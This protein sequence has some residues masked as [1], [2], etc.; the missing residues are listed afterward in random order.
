VAR[1]TAPFDLSIHIPGMRDSQWKKR[2]R[3][4]MRH[5]LGVVSS[6]QALDLGMSTSA[7]SRMV[8]SGAWIRVLPRVYRDACAPITF[9]Q[10]LMA[11]L[12]WAGEGSFVSHRAAAALWGL[13]AFDG[14]IVEISCPRYL[15]CP[16]DW[17]VVHT[18]PWTADLG[19]LQGLEV[20]SVARTLIELGAVVDRNAVEMALESGLRRRMTALRKLE[21]LMTRAK[22]VRGSRDLRLVLARRSPGA[23]PTASALETRAIQE[24]RRQ[25]LP[26]P[27]RQ[28]VV[29]DGTEF[30][31]R[32]DLAYPSKQ[33]VVEVDSR[34]Y[35]DQDPD[36]AR[37]IERRNRITA[38]GYTVM[39]VTH[40]NLVQD[41]LA[42]ARRLGH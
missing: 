4:L 30:V 5:Q 15:K 6:A 13:D 29:M 3:A 35:H 27:Q 23:P 10:R 7:I 41:V 20:T 19:K 26:D 24:I 12:L 38:L 28:L 33:L 8:K 22:G 11:A 31:A 32:V 37:D 25:G 39:H 42:I 21:A 36:W 16:V 2:L 18:T 14:E 9:K 40:A 34:R 17:V 1:A